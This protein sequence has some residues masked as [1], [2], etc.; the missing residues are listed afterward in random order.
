MVKGGSGGGGRGG[1]YG[2]TAAHTKRWGG[3]TGGVLRIVMKTESVYGAGDVGDRGGR[4][5]R[6]A[7]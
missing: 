6:A 5:V 7:V 3:S 1:R 4:G 2:A